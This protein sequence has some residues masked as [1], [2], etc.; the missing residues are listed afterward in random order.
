[1][2]VSIIRV[3]ATQTTRLCQD[4]INMIVYVYMIHDNSKVSGPHTTHVSSI[5]RLKLELS[6]LTVGM[7]FSPDLKINTC[8]TCRIQTIH[9]CCV[10]SF[11]LQSTRIVSTFNVNGIVIPSTVLIQITEARRFVVSSSSTLKSLA[12]NLN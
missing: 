12:T 8:L 9:G 7:H 2:S 11:F 6:L 10:P 5:C 1:M 4:R 3:C